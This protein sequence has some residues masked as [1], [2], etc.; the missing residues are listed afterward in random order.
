MTLSECFYPDAHHDGGGCSVFPHAEHLA[1]CPIPITVDTCTGG[2]SSPDCTNSVSP[3]DP[4]NEL[5]WECI[6]VEILKLEESLDDVM[7]RLLRYRRAV[8]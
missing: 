2:S 7:T 3:D 4:D 5:C 6:Q 8:K 1:E